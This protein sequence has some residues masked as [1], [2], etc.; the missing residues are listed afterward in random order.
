MRPLVQVISAAD[1]R[2]HAGF[3][4]RHVEARRAVDAVAVEQRHGRHVERWQRAPPVLRGRRR[5]EKAESGAGV[6]FDSK[7]SS[8]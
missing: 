2:A 7:H 1:V 3:F 8:R 6:Q 5:L 4:R